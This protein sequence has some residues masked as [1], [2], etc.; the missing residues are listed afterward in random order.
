MINRL[1]NKAGL[2][3]SHVVMSGTVD[4]FKLASPDIA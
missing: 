4:W 2:L 1:C 3:L